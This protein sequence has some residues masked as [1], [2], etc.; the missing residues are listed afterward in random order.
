[1][2]P[3]R[4]FTVVAILSVTPFVPFMIYAYEVDRHMGPEEV[5]LATGLDA[6]MIRLSRF[7]DGVGPGDFEK[8]SGVPYR[9]SF[10]ANPSI[11]VQCWIETSYGTQNA[12]KYCHTPQLTRIK[13]GN[14]WPM[15]VSIEAQVLY[16]FERPNLNKVHWENVVRPEKRTRRLQAMG[17]VLPE[18]G[19]L[20]NLDWVRT[21]NWQEAYDQARPNG[22]NTWD[23]K[24]NPDN[25]LRLIPALNPNHLYPMQG[26][27]PTAGGAHGYVDGEGFVR[28][29][30]GG[31]TGWR[32]VNF[33]PYAIFMPLAGS[34]SGIYIRLPEPFSTERG[35]FNLATYKANLDLLEKAI[36]TPGFKGGT[37]DGDASMV[38]VKAGLYPVGTEFAHPLHYVDSAADGEIGTDLDGVIS[39]ASLD[40]EFPGLRAKRVKEVRYSYKW[41]DLPVEEMKEPNQDEQIVGKQW[42][43]WVA[44]G[45]GWIL[46]AYIEDAEGRL[47]PQTTEEMLQ[48]VGCHGR[49]G[50]TVDSVWSFHRKLPGTLGWAEMNYGNYDSEH[51]EITQLQDYPTRTESVDKG[52]QEYFYWSVVGADLLGVMPEEIKRELKHFARE[53]G[54]KQELKLQH[55]IELIFNDEVLK[56]QPEEV[57]R[58]ILKER[59]KIMRR[60]ASDRAYLV[61]NPKSGKD[62]ISGRVFYPTAQTVQNNIARYRHILLDQSYNLGKVTFG[63]DAIPFTFRSDGIVRNAFNEKVPAGEVIMHRPWGKTGVGLMP[64]GITPVNDDQE[65]ID[66]DGNTIDPIDNA[67]A[68]PGHVANG[69]TFDVGYNPIL[70]DKPIAKPP[71]N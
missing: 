64:T 17:V 5:S 56:D 38:P 26:D 46:A 18:P 66:G 57:R 71:P 8:W 58:P 63:T 3:K 52:E 47:R 43:G 24:S 11:P 36:K 32:A 27:D 67:E 2:S 16:S 50:N 49:V 60:Y 69:G 55:E 14:G 15:K 48:C 70:R 54:L 34:V 22:D 12:C 7:I 4:L 35:E 13:H 51:P 41:R 62:V 59:A 6:E 21:G 53:H 42:Q 65:I 29:G 23:N 9:P 39:A 1:M 19:N 68:A 30:R 10:N 28:D 61:R 37:Y 33:F 25:P 31:Y 40:Y 44:N 45:H 20:D